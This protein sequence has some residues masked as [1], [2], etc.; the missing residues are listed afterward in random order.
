MAQYQEIIDDKARMG[1]AMK[2]AKE[3]ASDLQKR[4]SIM[5]KVANGGA[6]KKGKRK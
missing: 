4:V 5:N 1:R 6:I 2:V 3:Q